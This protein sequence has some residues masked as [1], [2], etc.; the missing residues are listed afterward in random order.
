MRAVLEIFGKGS[1]LSPAPYP[2]H[3]EWPHKYS[4]AAAPANG[5]SPVYSEDVA[6]C[7]KL[8]VHTVDQ[9]VHHQ[10]SRVSSLVAD[11]GPCYHP[12]RTLSLVSGCTHTHPSGEGYENCLKIEREREREREKPF[13]LKP[14]VVRGQEGP[15]TALSP[16]LRS[17]W[18]LLIQ[19]RS[20]GSLHSSFLLFRR[21]C[22][23]GRTNSLP[24]AST[25]L[26]A[27]TSLCNGPGREPLPPVP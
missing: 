16:S 6:R 23:T 22:W 12:L 20:A 17:L 9:T 14:R 27:R 8:Q 18:G 26:L 2:E 4:H 7:H 25:P 1:R 15:L 13:W 10:V 19:T 21:D 11:S 24:G 5:I 3:N